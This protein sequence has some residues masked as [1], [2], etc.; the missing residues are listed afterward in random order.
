[1]ESLLSVVL[2]LQSFAISLFV[3]TGDFLE[4]RTRTAKAKA[5][6]QLCDEV[7]NFGGEVESSSDRGSRVGT[8]FRSVGPSQGKLSP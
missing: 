8:V 2:E 3:G 7:R 5:Q 4:G 1:M 6:G